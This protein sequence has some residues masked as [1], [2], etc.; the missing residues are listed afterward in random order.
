M[1]SSIRD[2]PP[3]LT[4]NRFGT[5]AGVFTPCVLTI[6]GVIMFLRFGF[7]V[8]QAGIAA[9]LLIVVASNAITVLT[10]LSLSSIATNTKVEGGGVYFLIS[11]SLGP[12]FGGAIGLVFFAAQALSVAMYVI[13]FTE[14][15]MIY[16][17]E[18]TAPSTVAVVTN[19]AVFISV[20]I[21]AGWTLKLQFFI[22]A[23]V[24]AA[25]VSFYIGAID[26]F[27]WQTFNQNMGPSFTDGENFWTLFALFFPAVTGIMAGANM[28]GDLANP[29]R[30]IPKGTL[31]A[32]AVTFVIY[33][34]QALFLGGSRERSLLLSDSLII[35]DIAVMAALIGAGVI[36]ATLSSALGSMMGAPRILQS[37]A[38]DNLF[39]ILTPLAIGSG[40]ASE[41]R[42]AILLTFVISTIGI[43]AA[44]LNTIAPLITMAFLVT[45]GLLNLAT[46]YEAITKNPSYRPQFRYC[47][48]MTSLSGAIGCGAVMLLIDWRWA[49]VAVVLVAILHYYLSKRE[50]AT[51]WGS[52]QSGLLFERTRRNLV[53]LEDE[54]YHPKN[55]RP[56]VLALS[57][58]GF[59]RLYLVVMG[60]WLTA[61]TGVLTLGQIIAGDLRER[62]A[63]RNSQEK[64]LHAMIRNHEL[65]A[66][67][68]V[69]VASDYTRGVEALVQCQGLGRLRPNLVLLGCPLSRDRMEVFGGMLRN[70]QGLGRSVI[71]LRRSDE[72]QFELGAQDPELWKAPSGTIDVWWR[73]RANGE[74][75]VLLAHLILDHSDWAGHKLRLLRVVENDAGVVEVQSHLRQLLTEARIDGEIKVVVSDDPI[76][77]I[78][79]ESRTAAFV[80]LG[81]AVPQPGQEDAL[82]DRIE[83]I[84]RELPRVALVHSAGEM[85]LE[86]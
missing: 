8:G 67:P 77:A 1:R 78:S 16:L 43:L 40:K 64:M 11:R 86:S 9:T 58:T 83:G 51:D 70:L 32:I 56:F 30:S 27:D 34:S 31:L 6:L 74:L 69:I 10:A 36:A 45:Y 12:E 81:F 17:P 61:G 42:R 48:P 53:R 79:W 60:H 82:F 66:F 47:H 3:P 23:T 29:A 7:V 15:A 63:Q 26:T 18:G 76:R 62:R 55:W 21:G 38:K 4:V 41:P 25:L 85:S 22:L 49:I 35:A 75:M 28:S 2:I 13:G 24:I 19:I 68:A 80:F 57:G 84:T 54:L 59:S 65:T 20:F 14:A 73:G 44:D 50:I 52:L 37:L 72:N 5:F 39:L 33:V 46:F 71:V